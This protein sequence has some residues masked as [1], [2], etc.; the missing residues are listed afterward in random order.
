MKDEIKKYKPDINKEE[1]IW[2]KEFYEGIGN[3]LFLVE[4]DTDTSLRQGYI[5]LDQA[6][7]RF[8]LNYLKHIEKAD[9]IKD[10]KGKP[11]RFDD[12][13]SASKNKIDKSAG[14]LYRISQRHDV[15]DEL[16]HRIAFTL[17]NTFHD[18]LNDII[19]LCKLIKLSDIDDK[20]NTEKHDIVEKVKQSIYKKNRDDFSRILNIVGEFLNEE[21]KIM[22]GNYVPDILLG[23]VPGD[24]SGAIDN[25]KIIVSG[26]II[27][28]KKIRILELI[29][30]DTEIF[31]HTFLISQEGSM[32][33]YCFL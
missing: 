2:I 24:T 10:N 19:S 4:Q 23:C 7:E 29:D 3:A 32:L 13:I 20:I 14:L 21:F 12:I 25:I 26:M 8:L 1:E 17:G 15:R 5:L 11:V 31:R 22:N 6:L 18:Y 30:N 16:Q 9:L 28:D 27:N 33:W